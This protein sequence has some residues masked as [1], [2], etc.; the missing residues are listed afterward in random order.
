MKM[1]DSQIESFADK[2]LGEFRIAV[3]SMLKNKATA[4][5]FDLDGTYRWCKKLH[6]VIRF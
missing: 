3:V 2:I 5:A 1:T 4:H 6:L